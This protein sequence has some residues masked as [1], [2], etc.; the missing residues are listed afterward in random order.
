MSLII[1]RDLKLKHEKTLLEV[2]E[3]LKNRV[4]DEH[5]QHKAVQERRNSTSNFSIKLAESN[6]LNMSMRKEE[7]RFKTFIRPIL[8]LTTQ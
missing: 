7:A 4:Q 5:P 1:R 2:L 6:D 8:T 3:I